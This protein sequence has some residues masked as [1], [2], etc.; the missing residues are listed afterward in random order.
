MDPTI[1][2]KAYWSILKTFLNNKKIPCI[3]PIYHNNNY[4]TDFKEKAQIFND[5][6]AK[7]CTLVENSSKL[8]T[9]SFKRTN[10]LLSTISFTKDDIAKIIKNLNP[11][12]AHGFD[13]ISIRMIK[14]CVES[15]LKPLELIFKSCLENCKFPIEWKKANVA[16][17]HKRNNKQLI[18][19]YRPVSLLPVCGKILERLI[20][21]KTFELFTENE[22]ISQN[23]SGFKPGH[24]CI[25]QLLCIT[26]DVYQ[27]LDDGLE[28][29]V[30]FLDTSKVF[31]KVWH[32]ALLLKLKQNG[33]SGNLLNV[34]TDFLYQRKQRVVLNGQHLSWTNVEA[35]V[36]Q[37]SILGPLFFL[38]YIND[39]SF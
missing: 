34:I 4:I 36:P 35:G 6:F 12:K 39:L 26:H 11:N 32:E 30:V 16:P 22:L 28:T 20:Y 3:P 33:I 23:Q 17:V 8:P 14:I 1:S 38:I 5:F 15:I 9:N 7:Q 18:E 10:N 19:N 24:S 27:S 29:R 25:S 37:G 31:D 13:M 2:P 21:N